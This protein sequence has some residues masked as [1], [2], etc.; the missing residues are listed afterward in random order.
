MEVH[1][2]ETRKVGGNAPNNLVTVCH[3][4][5]QR[6]HNK[7]DSLTFKFKR[8]VSFKDSSAVSQMRKRVLIELKLLFPNISI[9]ETYGYITKYNRIKNNLPKRHSIDALVIT[10]NLSVQSLDYIYKGKQNRNHY[11][12]LHEMLPKKGGIRPS[13]TLPKYIYGYQISDKVLC[14][15][16]IGFISG[17]RQSGSFAVKDIKGDFL[18]KGIVYKKLRLVESRKSLM[19][20]VAE[21]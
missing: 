5:H 8:G 9:M 20:F 16:K 21:R 19:F 11:R 18:S 2:I 3:T 12:Q 10:G 1:H 7:D 13:I 6:H 14:N 4:C 15:G 17:R